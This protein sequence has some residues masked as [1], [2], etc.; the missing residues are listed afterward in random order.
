MEHGN[1]F[2]I[3]IGPNY[4]GKIRDIDVQTLQQVGEMIRAGSDSEL[5]D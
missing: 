4:A 3:N 5:R 1:I 2:S